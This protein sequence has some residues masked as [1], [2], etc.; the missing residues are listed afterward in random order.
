[1]E[2]LR[3][4]NVVR[5]HHVYKDIWTPFVGEILHVEQEDNNPEDC[6]AVCIVK[7]STGGDNIVGH[8]PREVSQL[9]WYFIEHNG[10][11]VCEITGHRKR[12]IGL[13]VPCI[14]TFS[15]KKKMIRKLRR[16]LLEGKNAR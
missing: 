15:A 9:V 11:V 14:Y 7:G 5:G 6:F 3:W 8:M 10:S 12:G 13:E 2:S 16:K 4:N 1:M